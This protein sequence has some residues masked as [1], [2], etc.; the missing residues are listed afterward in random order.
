M[1]SLN[2]SRATN[3]ACAGMSL[4]GVRSGHLGTLRLS[5]RS[6][7]APPAGRSGAA[8]DESAA[9]ADIAW[10]RLDAKTRFVAIND[11]AL[12][13]WE[14]AEA[15]LFGRPFLDVFPQAHGSAAWRQHLAVMRNRCPARVETRSLVLRRWINVA[16]HPEADGGLSVSFQDISDR[17][18]QAIAEKELRHRFANDIQFVLSHLDLARRRIENAEVRALLD[19]A[20]DRATFSARLQRQLLGAAEE[21]IDPGPILSDV[22]AQT[23]GGF[24]ALQL[25][26]ALAPMTL[27]RAQVTSLVL[28]VWEAATNA[29]KH[30]F[31]PGRGSRFTLALAV[32]VDGLHL[33]IADDG[34]GLPPEGAPHVP[35]HGLGRDIMGELAE[36]MGGR[37]EIA[38]GPGTR[39]HLHLPA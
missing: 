18:R 10:Y 6:R 9:P 22:V 36:E 37:L 38:P 16:L 12:R 20:I 25:D 34:P 27:P 19:H 21:Q 13:L 15:D 31:R 30:V 2:L 14:K 4:P 33:T 8:G 29:A 7:T 3:N 23:L 5:G 1:A 11:T 32:D 35:S 39:L 17:R 24:P 26:L 28:L